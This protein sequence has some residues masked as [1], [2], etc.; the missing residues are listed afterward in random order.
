MKR[1][2]QLA[3]KVAVPFQPFHTDPKPCHSTHFKHDRLARHTPAH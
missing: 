2:R 3:A 1:L